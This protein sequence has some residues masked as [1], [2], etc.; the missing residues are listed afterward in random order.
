MDKNTSQSIIDKISNFKI[1]LILNK[2]LYIDEVITK[3]YYEVVE[4]NLLE[5]INILS[6]ELELYV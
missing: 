4:N 6:N 2:N 1:Q 3:E 5:K